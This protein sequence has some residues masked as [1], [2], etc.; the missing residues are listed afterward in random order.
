MISSKII[1]TLVLLVVCASA[2]AQRR[3]PGSEQAV[4]VEV[5]LQVGAGKYAATSPGE[6]KFSEQGSI[7]GLQASQYSVSQSAG[8][9]SLHLVLWQPKTGGAAMLG[10]NVSMD[11]KRY[12]VDT[13][14]AGSK[15]QT[16]GSGQ[17]KVVKGGAGATFVVDAVTKGGE[18]ITGTIKCPGFDSIRAEGG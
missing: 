15:T 17:A 14:K 11:G 8:S 13:V 9:R 16:S 6:C 3:G 7:Y 2:A 4:P 1:F 5:A 18:K 10:L 12:D